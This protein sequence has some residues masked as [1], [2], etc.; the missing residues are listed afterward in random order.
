[1]GPKTPCMPKKS[2][3]CNFLK[4]DREMCMQEKHSWLSH[5]KKIKFLGKLHKLDGSYFEYLPMGVKN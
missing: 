3:Q 4:K 2:I 1:M 5:D